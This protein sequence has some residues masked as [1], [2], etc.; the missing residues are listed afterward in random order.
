LKEAEMPTKEELET[1]LEKAERKI[2]RL[3]GK[4]AELEIAAAAMQA[5]DDSPVFGLNAVPLEQR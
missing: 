5:P 3:E 4:V 2:A 1:A